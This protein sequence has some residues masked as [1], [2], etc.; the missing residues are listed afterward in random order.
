MRRLDRKRLYE[1]EKLGQTV[2]VGTSD[3]MKDAL[4]SASQHRQ[5]H[6]LT[7]DMLFD[8]GTAK[9]TM[10]TKALAAADPVGTAGTGV[11]YLCQITDAV[12][13][14]VTTV[15]V[16]TLEAI[17]DGTLVN[18]NLMLGDGDGFFGSDAGNDATI[19]TD[20]G[21][22][23][24]IGATGYDDED[25]KDKYLYLTSGAA[26]SQKASAEID[27]TNLVVG[28]L[29][30]GVTTIRLINSDGATAVAFVADTGTAHADPAQ[31]NKFNCAGTPSAAQLA[32]SIAAAIEN[33]GDF[34]ASVTDTTKVTVTHAASTAASNHANYL[35]NDDPQTP[36]GI[37]VGAFTGGI[38]DGQ[39]MAS[40]KVLIRVTGFVAPDDLA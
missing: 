17:S 19:Q 21:A 7:T 32:T 37:T 16:F 25:L 10:L 24:Y 15:E 6:M 30:N 28:N 27:C 23:G 29:V 1:V 2:D 9:A 18:F 20:I 22:I 38:D 4:V 34:T 36:V 31:A 33:D 26:T 5:G 35:V 14:I 39:A 8:F 13:G 40:G 12:F 11:S 3:V